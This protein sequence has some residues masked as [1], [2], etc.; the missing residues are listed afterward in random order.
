MGI[1]KENQEKFENFFS[2][3][4]YRPILIGKFKKKHEKLIYI[5]EK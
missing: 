3:K 4:P 1:K 5:N 2:D